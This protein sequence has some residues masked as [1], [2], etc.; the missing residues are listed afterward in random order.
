MAEVLDDA[1]VVVVAIEKRHAGAERRG[2]LLAHAQQAL[3]H[4]FALGERWQLATPDRVTRRHRRRIGAWRG[5]DRGD[6]RKSESAHQVDAAKQHHR[7]AQAIERVPLELQ[8]H[9]HGRSLGGGSP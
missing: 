8:I 1:E 5:D 2:Q 3:D 4:G 7:R 9:A 6:T